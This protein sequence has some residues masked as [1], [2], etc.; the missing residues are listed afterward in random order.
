MFD[1]ADISFIVSLVINNEHIKEGTP[2]L[3]FNTLRTLMAFVAVFFVWLILIMPTQA[4]SA[5]AVGGGKSD[6]ISVLGKKSTALDVLTNLN[7]SNQLAY[8]RDGDDTG[9]D[10]DHDA[11]TGTRSGSNNGIAVVTG[12]NAGIGAVCCKT[13]ALSGQVKVVVLCARNVQ[14]AQTLVDSW[15]S[16]ISSRIEIQQLDL[17]DLASVEQAAR[18]ITAR[19][20][21]GDGTSH[22]I[23]ILL[24]NAG[25]MAPP[26]KLV[27]AQDIELQFGV[28]HVGHHMW[29]RLLL[30]HMNDDGRIVT[31]AST[32]HQMVSTS[33]KNK[34]MWQ[35]SSPDNYSGWREYGQSKLA[36]ILFAKRLQELLIL[37]GKTGIHSVS[38]HPGVIRTSLWQ[39][40]P[41]LL[42]P[43]TR[44]I[45]DKTV[46]QGAA[47][48]VYCCLTD[49]IQGAA[50]YSDCNVAQPTKTAEDVVLRKELWDY[51]EALI[52]EKGFQLPE[53]IVGGEKA[54]DSDAGNG[55]VTLDAYTT[56]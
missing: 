49:T 20:C 48:S 22:G 27:T 2:D 1:D 40:I 21:S 32:A 28:N 19:H 17:A 16:H 12:G 56:I 10:D 53:N 15:P 46:E 54:T 36:N 9:R 13:L 14:A 47:T 51:T 33:G 43:L 52:R 45:A 6:S 26:K 7:R 34:I 11:T 44:L 24:N 55:K 41:R 39:Y 35:Q 8:S 37:E 29:T 38:L 18:E 3:T 25:V 50:Y 23:S 31:V 5:A 4:W 30:P 42:R